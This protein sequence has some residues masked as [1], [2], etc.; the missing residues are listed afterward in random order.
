MGRRVA[1]CGAL[2]A[3]VAMP[4]GCAASTDDD[5]APAVAAL[6][7]A[8]DCR[9]GRVLCGRA[10][11]DMATD[12]GHCGAC[13]NRCRGRSTC[14]AGACTS[15]TE[16]LGPGPLAPTVDWVGQISGGD[17]ATVCSVDTEGYPERCLTGGGARMTLSHGNDDFNWADSAYNWSAARTTIPVRSPASAACGCSGSCNCALVGDAWATTSGGTGLEYLSMMMRRSSD[18]QKFIAIAATEPSNID[19]NVWTFPATYIPQSADTDG[20]AMHFDPAGSRLWLADRPNSTFAFRLFLF[21]PCGYGQ[22]GS[23]AC[24]LA[25][26]FPVNVVASGINGHANV[27]ANPCTGHAIALWNEPDPSLTMGDYRIRIAFY[28]TS[29]VEVGTRFTIANGLRWDNNTSCGCGGTGHLCKC[30]ACGDA[31][32]M[33]VFPRVHASVK[34]LPGGECRL[35][36]A[37]DSTGTASDTHSYE[38]ANFA[39]IDISPESAPSV[40]LRR[41]SSMYWF[42]RNEFEGTV[43]LNQYTNGCGFFYY[44]QL[45]GD[46]CTTQYLG[47]VNTNLCQDPRTFVGPFTPNFR[48]IR[49]SNVAGLGDYVGIVRAGLSSGVLFPSWS[50]PIAT[51]D[52]GC[53]TTCSDGTRYSMRVMGARITP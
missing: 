46:P 49:F 47:Q 34:Y 28:N 48:T 37:Y 2:V 27:I 43:S 51:S 9:D 19:D 45:G 52:T 17:P 20:P 4:I 31:G 24:P 8:T 3:T 29:G 41:R 6:A 18:G 32:C 11:V 1:A 35:I 25:S 33:R 5:V 26:G 42:P 13:D 15:G 16:P 21:Y 23:S 38:K 44:R 22:P 53:L 36:V 10:C 7:A 30:D 40:L 14:L 12:S 50:E 39:L